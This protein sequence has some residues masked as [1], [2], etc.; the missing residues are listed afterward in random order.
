[1]LQFG[2]VGI[3][4]V[5]QI[6]GLGFCPIALLLDVFDFLLLPSVHFDKLLDLLVEE[7]APL[8]QFLHFPEVLPPNVNFL[9]LDRIELFLLVGEFEP[10]RL[11]LDLQVFLVQ[12]LHLQLHQLLFEVQLLGL[13]GVVLRRLLL[14]PFGGFG[15]GGR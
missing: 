1:V 2:E 11:Q 15:L 8:V 5:L 7:F 12:L 10:G 4:L 13:Q 3:V 6:D 14:W 9:L